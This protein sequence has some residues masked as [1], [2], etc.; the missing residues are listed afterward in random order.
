MCK[1]QAFINDWAILD[2]YEA[3]NGIFPDEDGFPNHAFSGL[4]E[5]NPVILFGRAVKDPRY[6]PET[7]HWADGGRFYTSL[8]CEFK[9][10]IAITEN[11]VYFLGEINEEYK[12]WCDSNNINWQ[13]FGDIGFKINPEQYRIKL[14][15]GMIEGVHIYYDFM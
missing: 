12:I 9:E 4:N 15:L 8:V 2:Y 6:D 14:Y 11:T 13:K 1:K 7:G 5:E 3:R 10:G